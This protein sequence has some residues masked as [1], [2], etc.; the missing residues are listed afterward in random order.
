MSTLMG[1]SLY[2]R[3]CSWPAVRAGGRSA[4]RGTVQAVRTFSR[5]TDTELAGGAG[6]G[7]AHQPALGLLELVLELLHHQVDGHQ[8]HRALRPGPGWSARAR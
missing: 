6:M 4:A 8:R 1:Y 2:L 7:P 5:R 3:R